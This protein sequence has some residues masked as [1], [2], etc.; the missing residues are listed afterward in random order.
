MHKRRLR[1][2]CA[3]FF[4]VL[5]TCGAYA[6]A[7]GDSLV[8]LSYLQNIFIPDAVKKGNEAADQK[9]QQTYDSAKQELDGVQQGLLTQGNT[10]SESTGQ[11]S[12]VLNPQDWR[13]GDRID[14][15]TGSGFLVREGVVSVAHT[16]AVIDITG[17]VEM[18]VSFQAQASHRYLVAEN[19][20]ATLTVLSG[21]AALAV[22]GGFASHTSG[23]SALPFYDVASNS[24]FASGVQYVYSK[25]LFQGVDDTHFSPDT[26]MN[27]AM[28]MTVLYRLAGNPG[29]GS[30]KSSFPDVKQGTW[31]YD[32][33]R[34]GAK[35]GIVTGMEDGSFRPELALNREQAVVFL[36]RYATECLGERSV[37]QVN[38]SSYRDQS[39]VSVWAREA[40]TWAVEKGII[41]SASVTEQILSPKTNATRAQMA[42]M[43]QN[44]SEKIL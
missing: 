41:T 26:E 12:D 5:I 40:F 2:L 3:V 28:M 7:T 38:L 15:L 29:A 24:W 9:L 33:V 20:E 42:L 25:G 35:Q 11:Y 13:Q 39:Q 21:R 27:R 19:T 18:P 30:G 23:K 16:G 31:Y 37:S 1:L 34:W 4:L 43:L 36:Y 6:A 8:S 32:S 10:G 17:G 22:Q 14:L 44:F